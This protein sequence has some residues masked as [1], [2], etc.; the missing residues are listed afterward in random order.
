MTL[1]GA[2]AKPPL[3]ASG[4]L[5]LGSLRAFLRD[6]LDHLGKRFTQYGDIVSDRMAHVEMLLLNDTD[7]IG[8]VLSTNA[9]NYRK[10]RHYDTLRPLLGNGLVVSD[11]ADWMAQRRTVGPTFRKATIEGFAATMIDIACDTASEWE[12]E[13]KI[14][15]FPQMARLAMDVV[16]RTVLN[17]PRGF[18]STPLGR[19]INFGI[20]HT[21]AMQKNPLH[22]PL[23]VPT[24]ANRGFCAA[25]QTVRT[26]LLSM[27]EERRNSPPGYQDVLASL[28]NA[29]DEETGAAM[30]DEQILDQV[31]SFFIAGFETTASTLCWVW[32]ELSRNPAVE[33]ALHAEIDHVTGGALVQPRHFGQLKYTRKVILEVLRLYPPAWILGR[34]AIGVDSLGDYRVPA[35]RDVMI[36]PFWKHRDPRHWRRPFDF[37]PSHFDDAEA[38]GRHRFAFLPF[39]AGPRVCIGEHFAMLELVLVIACLAQRFTLRMPVGQVVTIEPASVLRIGGDSLRMNLHVRSPRAPARVGSELD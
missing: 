14:D 20:R 11:G 26:S 27:I 22:L 32:V 5:N 24:P 12:R 33:R 1:R 4:W 34:Q 28:I 10:S 38:A 3:A 37:D 6:P 7:L 39:G 23:Y 8:Q 31:L 36:S 19:A 9:K 18:E 29:R 17:S 15:V 30:S 25:T 16:S 13:D 35:G 21:G 2:H